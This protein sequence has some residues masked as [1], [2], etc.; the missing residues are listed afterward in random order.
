[1]YT[2]TNFFTVSDFKPNSILVS[3]SKVF[4]ILIMEQIP[5]FSSRSFL[6]PLLSGYRSGHSTY[7]AMLKVP[8]DIRHYF[9]DDPVDVVY[10]LSDHSA[11]NLG[12][13]QG[14]VIEPLIFSILFNDLSSIINPSSYHL[15]ADDLHLYICF[16]EYNARMPIEKFRFKSELFQVKGD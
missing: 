12:V 3:I 10:R 14:A 9:T 15:F 4:E 16:T 1:M 11:G 8:N 7:T 13:A 6:C 2:K 5:R